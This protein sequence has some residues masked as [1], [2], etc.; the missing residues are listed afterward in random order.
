MAILAKYKVSI[1]RAI[2]HQIN[3]YTYYFLANPTTY[4]NIETITGVK[5]VT[6]ANELN[7]PTTKVGELIGAGILSRLTAS[8]LTSTNKRRSYYILALRSRAGLVQDNL[9]NKT[10]QGIKITSVISQRKAIFY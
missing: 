9:V 4:L 6:D 5:R 10:I 7:Q 2:S 3:T 1:D 8:G